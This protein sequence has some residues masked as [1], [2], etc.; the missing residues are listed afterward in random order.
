MTRVPHN[1]AGGAGRAWPVPLALSSEAHEGSKVATGKP[2]LDNGYTRIANELL[3]A[4]CRA[5]VTGAEM[6][7]LF[8]VVRLTYGWHRRANTVRAADVARM[9]N[10]H[11]QTVHAALR[12]LTAR[13]F[14][15][16][17]GG[18]PGRAR[19]IGLNKRYKQWQPR[20]PTTASSE[21]TDSLPTVSQPTHHLVSQPTHHLVS[22]PATLNPCNG[23]R[24]NTMRAPKDSLKD[25]LKDKS[26]DSAETAGP[27]PGLARHKRAGL[28]II[29]LLFGT[30]P[31]RPDLVLVEDR[32]LKA[33]EDARLRE[34]VGKLLDALG[35]DCPA[36]KAGKW[37]GKAVKAK[38]PLVVIAETL[39]RLCQ[40][41][42]NRTLEG[43]PWAYAEK[44]RRER[45][46]DYHANNA[47]RVNQARKAQ[48]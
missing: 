35:T 17:G 26:H 30:T 2:D 44:V 5:P 27:I 16:S 45:T 42:L 40:A 29:G 6:R 18:G 23:Q 12:E 3:E 7:T 37:Y 19:K 24:E 21:P 11:L 15:H 22:Q 36:F 41:I 32:K 33:H 39:T 14:L 43:S 20:E 8:A 10:L 48:A 9:T 4:L 13:G 31:E 28:Q 38:T 34:Q 47:D 1:Q 46:A 25:R